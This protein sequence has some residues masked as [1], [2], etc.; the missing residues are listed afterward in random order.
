MTSRATAFRPRPPACRRWWRHR[1]AT[2]VAAAVAL[3]GC[4]AAVMALLGSS[5]PAPARS[6]QY[7]AHQACLLTGPNGIASGNDA[8]VW[9]G[10]EDASLATRA[11]V[12]YLTVNGPQTSGNALPYANTLVQ[13]DC[14]LVIGTDTAPVQ[15]LTQLARS[16]PRTHFLLVTAGASTRAN[17]R[18][19]PSDG[20]LRQRVKTAVQYAVTR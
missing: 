17:L 1:R 16:A 18:T 12:S 15:A 2:G 20:D 10:M 7:T 13:R 4:A 9:A 19:L 5:T 11:K 14:D 3:V 8:T 6:R